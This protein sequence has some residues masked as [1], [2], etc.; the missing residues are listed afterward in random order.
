MRTA[1]AELLDERVPVETKADFLIALAQKGE[2]V[3]EISLFARELRSRA[4]EPPIDARTRQRGILDVCGTGGDRLNT[5]NIS[6]TV[7]LVVA[8]AGVCVA[9]HGNRAITSQ[10]GSADVL[11]AL[12]IPIDLSPDAAAQTLRDHQFAFLFAPRLST[13]VS[14]TSPRRGASAPIAANALFSISWARSSIPLARTR[15]SWE[16]LELNWLSRSRACSRPWVSGG[17]WLFPAGSGV[18]RAMNC[19]SSATTRLP[20]STTNAAFPPGRC[21]WTG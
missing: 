10:A 13:R 11:E 8:A 15:N 16:S 19:P 9:K 14:G 7:A 4:A 17:A 3:D 21:R 18:P 1:V 20:S 12:G 6:T 2:T 5:F